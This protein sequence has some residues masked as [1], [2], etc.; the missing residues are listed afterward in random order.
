MGKK[1]ECEISLKFTEDGPEYLK[2][3]GGVDSIYGG[4]LFGICHVIE[5]SGDD[6]EG[7]AKMFY[8]GI[9]ECTI[10]KGLKVKF[11]GEDEIGWM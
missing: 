4:L 2:M 1:I 8:H 11:N 3:K 7:I 10:S 9:K 6:P 5:A